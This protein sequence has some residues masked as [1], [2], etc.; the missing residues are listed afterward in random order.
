MNKNRNSGF[1][2]SL[3]IIGFMALVGIFFFNRSGILNS[4]SKYYEILSLYQTDKILLIL[5]MFF[6]NQF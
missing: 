3:I 1:F 2:I 5:F 6:Q 4:G